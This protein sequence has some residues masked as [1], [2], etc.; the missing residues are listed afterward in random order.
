MPPPYH[1]YGCPC[2]PCRGYGG[3]T[4]NAK[5]A[6]QASPD[7]FVWWYTVKSLGLVAVAIVAAYALGK[8]SGLKQR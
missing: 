6:M 2:L 3:W 5:A 7:Y 1:A 8:S 4:E